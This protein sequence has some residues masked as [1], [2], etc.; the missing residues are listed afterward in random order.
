VN[1]KNY[2]FAEDTRL[3]EIAEVFEELKRDL[4]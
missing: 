2:S 3:E 1:L 4:L